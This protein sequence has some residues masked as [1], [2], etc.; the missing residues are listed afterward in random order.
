[1]THQAKRK[2]FFYHSWDC[3]L[4]CLATCKKCSKKGHYACACKSKSLLA[5]MVDPHVLTLYANV[6]RELRSCTTSLIINKI[7]QS[8]LLDFCSTDSYI[9]NRVAWELKLEIHPSNKKRIILAQKTLNTILRGYIV[10]NL[11]LCLNSQ[12]YVATRLGILKNLCSDVILS[13]DFLHQHQKITF[14]Y[15][16][17][18]P[19]L[20][21]DNNIHQFCTLNTAEIEEP[22]LFPNILPRHKPI[23]VKSRHFDKED[24]SFINKEI[25][26]LL[27]KGIIEESISSWQAQLVVVKDPTNHKKKQ[28]QC[29]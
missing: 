11:L 8:A 29:A 24:Q 5:T 16:R 26:K 19:E 4:A 10:V 18:L 15:G 7:Q 1:M 13:Q 28:K 6:P 22:S 17:P 21:V 14:K 25:Q 2:C 12:L 20:T 3:C 9:S 23:A 27:S